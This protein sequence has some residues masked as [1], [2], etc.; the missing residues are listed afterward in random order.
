MCGVM[1]QEMP[2]TG[3]AQ[4][5]PSSVRFLSRIAAGRPLVALLTL[6]LAACPRPVPLTKQKAEEILYGY[7]FARE[8]VYAEVPQ[9]VWWNARFPKDDYD[10]KALR[11]FDNLRNGGE[12]TPPDAPPPH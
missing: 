10:A 7:Q 5:Q 2:A 11:T 1:S 9:K 3:F 6:L 4:N 8:P 12:P